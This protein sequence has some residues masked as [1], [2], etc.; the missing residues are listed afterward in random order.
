[1]RVLQRLV[2]VLDAVSKRWNLVEYSSFSSS[3]VPRRSS[4]RDFGLGSFGRS[5]SGGPETGWGSGSR[6]YS[7]G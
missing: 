5:G 1:M 3:L 6:R 4:C 7:E 2:S